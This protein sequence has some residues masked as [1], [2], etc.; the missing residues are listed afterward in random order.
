MSTNPLTRLPIHG[1]SLRRAQTEPFEFRLVPEG[2]LVRNLKYANPAEHE[3][4]VTVEAGVPICCTCPADLHYD[5]ACKH[6]LAVAIRKPVLDAAVAAL[7]SADGGVA[8]RPRRDEND[9][10]VEDTEEEADESGAGGAEA[11]VDADVDERPP[12]CSCPDDP[13]GFPCWPCVRDGRKKLPE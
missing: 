13:E 2:V 4:L 8:G 1:P 11:N 3:Y 12:D 9:D 10:A 5:G 7:L 6:R